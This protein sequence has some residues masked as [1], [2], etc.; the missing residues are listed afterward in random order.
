MDATAN[1]VLTENVNAAVR[2]VHIRTHIGS[3]TKLQKDLFSWFP[4]WF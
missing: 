4:W 2:L 3:I 1:S